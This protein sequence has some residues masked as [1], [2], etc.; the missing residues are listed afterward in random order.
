MK[1]SWKKFLFKDVIIIKNMKNLIT[2]RNYITRIF[3]NDLNILKKLSN[4]Q[5]Q[6][7]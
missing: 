2:K 1:I 7:R 3:R 5:Y 6:L 4:S